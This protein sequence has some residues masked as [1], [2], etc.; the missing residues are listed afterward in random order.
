M[1]TSVLAVAATRGRASEGALLLAVYSAGL[2]VPFLAT[3]L[4]FG[5]MRGLF[6]WMR[7][8]LATVTWVTAGSLA[9]FGGLLV[10]NRLLWV[11]TQLQNGLRAVGLEGLV[12]LG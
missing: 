8:H 12:F 1:L 10:A 2:G 4:A 6:L 5:R 11:T 9:V 7:R 3:G